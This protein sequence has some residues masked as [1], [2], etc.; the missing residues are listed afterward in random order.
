MVTV[1]LALAC[2]APPVAGGSAPATTGTTPTTNTA[3]AARYD[4]SPLAFEANMG[5]AE[6][7]VSFVAHGKGVA[8]A[9]SPDAFTLALGG[10]H[11][12]KEQT[13]M[14]APS[15]TLRI[16]FAGANPAPTL[17]AEDA[18]PGVAN[19]LIGNDPAQWQTNVPTS[20]KV[21][22]RDLYPGIDLTVY[23]TNGGGG[24]EYDAIVA[25]GAA[26]SA[27]AL[28]ITGAETVMLDE[29][30]GE[31]V[32]TT[33]AGE[34]RQHAPVA[35]QEVNRARVPV[36]AQYD[37]RGDGTV[38]FAVGAY[39]DALPLV[40][41]PT[42]ALA[43]STY[44]GGMGGDYSYGIAADSTGAAYVTGYTTS[45]NFPTTAGA[46]GTMLRGNSNAF[47]TK[48][49][50]TG[51]RVYS[52]Y[53][54]GGG[55][56]IG[57]AIAVDGTGN[58]YVTGSTNG[59]FPTTSNAYE[60][61]YS[62]DEV[63]AFVTKLNAAGTALVYSTYLGGGSTDGGLGIAVDAS[64]LVYVT[65]Y[66]NGY[67]P[68]TPYAYQTNRPGNGDVFIAKLDLTQTSAAALVYA[69]YLG[70]TGKDDGYAIAAD[71]AGVV[72]VAGS[73]TSTNFPVA[74]TMPAP[75]AFQPT[76]GGGAGGTNGDAFVTKLDTT[77]QGS[78]ALVYSTYLGG[79]GDER[80]TGI[81]VDGNGNVYVTGTTGST[82]F[83]ITAASAYQPVLGGNTAAF[84][85]KLDT[86]KRGAA[87]LAYSTYLGGSSD[88]SGISIAAD[89]SGNVYV[90]GSTR[91]T[92]FPIAPNPG[93]VQ[94]TYGGGTAFGGDA[95][96]TKLDTTK[97]GAASLVY[98]TYLG[99]AGNDAG[100][101]IAIDGSGDVYVTGSTDS[102]N[103]PVTSGTTF[104][105]TIDA[106]VTKLSFTSAPLLTLSP[107]T[108]PA[109][110]VNAS[111][112]HTITATGGTGPYTYVVTSGAL[113][114]GLTLS[115]TGVLSGTP[116]MAGSY[117]FTVTATD[118]MGNTGSQQYTLVVAVPNPTPQPLPTRAPMG[119]PIAAPPTHLPGAAMSA[120]SPTP[121]PQPTRH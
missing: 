108:L 67:F 14:V 96:V 1:L 101:G 120:G 15:A 43:Y 18:L 50:S 121:L 39:D 16:A 80:A 73:T 23:G 4:A 88:D 84:V 48:L 110:G 28:A 11:S 112:S 40:I 90:T 62:G 64:G 81:A 38:G 118:S 100:N 34:V 10:Q 33:G 114:P 17:A 70:G 22:Y 93:A 5:Q 46:Y 89:N 61:N 63:S 79:A 119:N 37:M 98:S 53:L 55:T 25:P 74:P 6:A 92:N 49:S 12:A 47:V 21:R 7:G 111:Y 85:V 69:T 83:P 8:F 42:V 45:M 56:D 95:F 3:V 35:Y 19:Y 91:S 77:K 20:G 78:A 104:G 105:G 59:G 30:T 41:D 97:S 117:P 87:S 102:I 94:T 66:T 82:N 107:T 57:N 113:P 71:N 32:L 24:L 54:G 51:A 13:A 106:F 68:V 115:A 99:G 31:L 109:T 65:G 86:T 76:Y 60:T 27:F 26:P 36:A 9:L 29:A 52:T 116:T 75:G 58:A 2:L 103:F 72:Y 44:L